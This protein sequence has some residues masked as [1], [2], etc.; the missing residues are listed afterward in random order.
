MKLE[1]EIKHGLIQEKPKKKLL[2]TKIE[3]NKID[4]N[5]EKSDSE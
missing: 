1:N 2:F 4:E 3:E 5:D